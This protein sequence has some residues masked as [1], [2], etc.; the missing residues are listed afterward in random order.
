[1]RVKLVFYS[2]LW[3]DIP[4]YFTPSSPSVLQSEWWLWKEEFWVCSLVISISMDFPTES[5]YDLPFQTLPYWGSLLPSPLPVTVKFGSPVLGSSWLVNT[6]ATF[7]TINSKIGIL[8]S[9]CVQP[10][11]ISRLLLE[12]QEEKMISFISFLKPH[13]TFNSHIC[14]CASL[15]LHNGKSQSITLSVSLLFLFISKKLPH[16]GHTLDVVVTW[17]PVFIFLCSSS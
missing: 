9:S 12:L 14:Q 15:Y 10:A 3:W 7:P 6:Q 5:A 8:F 17:C 1:M 16:N 4:G 11:S 2:N 13:Y